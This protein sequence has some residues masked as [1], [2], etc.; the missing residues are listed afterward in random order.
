MEKAYVLDSF[1][2]IA[3]LQDEAGAEDVELILQAAKEK[4]TVVW[5]NEINLGEVLYTLLRRGGQ[6][7]A[8]SQMDALL[9]LPLQRVAN[10]WEMVQRAAY[11][12][13]QFPMAL[14]DC[15]A[16]ATAG[17]HEAT[18]VT[19]DPEFTAV[20]AH[21]KILWLPKKVKRRR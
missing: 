21:I 16:A 14:A 6:Q 19:G 18:L 10:E 3:Y 5:V 15:F 1:A 13:W 20:G 8:E 2:L 17:F 7:Y 9:R 12:K 11:I 4:K